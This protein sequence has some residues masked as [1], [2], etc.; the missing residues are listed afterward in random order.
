M[1]Y[2]RDLLNK[3]ALPQPPTSQLPPRLPPLPTSQ[4]QPLY[5]EHTDS[6]VSPL[7]DSTTPLYSNGHKNVQ[8][9]SEY[10]ERY[11]PETAKGAASRQYSDTIPLVENAQP[12]SGAT[13]D[14]DVAIGSTESRT[15]QPR[16]RRRTKEKEKKPFISWQT[17]WIVYFLSLVQASVFIAELVKNGK[18]FDISNLQ[19]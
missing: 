9:S 17:T 19:Y 12:I 16:P 2:S 10:F 4:F 11:T 5:Y 1:A 14:P 6:P 15:Q 13:E 3:K 8:D 7:F 18:A